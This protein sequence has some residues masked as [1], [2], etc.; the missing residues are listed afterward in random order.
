MLYCMALR[1]FPRLWA[2]VPRFF[3][4][5]P[6]LIFVFS[7]DG[8]KRTLLNIIS[9]SPTRKWTGSVS[10]FSFSLS[11]SPPLLRRPPNEAQEFPRPLYNCCIIHSIVQLFFCVSLDSSRRR[12]F[13]SNAG[14]SKKDPASHSVPPLLPPP[15]VFFSR[16]PF[17]FLTCSFLDVVARW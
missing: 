9:L 7:D 6:L 1:L 13:V 15:G 3:L 14:N 4:V 17:L 10:H 11:V 8:V 12:L 5:P 2:V 16:D